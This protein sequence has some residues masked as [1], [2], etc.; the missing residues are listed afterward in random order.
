MRV[1]LDAKNLE[2]QLLNIVDYSLGFIDGA[3]SGKKIFLD[4][5]GRGVIFALGR[6]ID[7]E[8]RSNREAL[9]H[10][11]EW[12]QTGSPEARLFDL[13]YTVSNLG[14]T[15]N[16]TFRQSRAVS[17]DGTEPFYNKARIMESGTPVTITPRLGGAL[18]FTDGG[19]EIF[20][21][22]PVVVNTPG[23]DEV[24][25]SFERVFDQFMMVYFTQAFL[26][27][28]GIFDYL[29]NPKIYKANFAAGA[30]MGKSKGVSTGFKWIT[31]AKIEVE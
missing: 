22:R 6:Y 31:N 15:I 14:L 17:R 13:K 12:Y 1:S 10:V 26:K 30:K 2:K 4:N 23:G 16:S 20:T 9:H 29:R 28:S 27:A 25:G 5:L 24:A 21:K 3:N 8:A 18:R 11:Y 19:N 7:S